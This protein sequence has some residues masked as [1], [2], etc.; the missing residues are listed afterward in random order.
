M[1]TTEMKFYYKELVEEGLPDA[2]ERLLLDCLN[3]DP[4]LFLRHDAVEIS[5]SLLMPV[6]QQWERRGGELAAGPLHPYPAGSW[7]PAA[8]EA[9]PAADGRAW[10]PV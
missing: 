8:A 10:V 9:L 3:A 7:G 4:T 2:Y 1:D 5:W 6:L